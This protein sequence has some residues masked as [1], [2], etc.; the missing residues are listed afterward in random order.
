M[1]KF[2]VYVLDQP[3]GNNGPSGNSGRHEEWNLPWEKL[4]FDQRLTYKREGETE[5]GRFRVSPLSAPGNAQH[6]VEPVPDLPLGGDPKKD[7][8]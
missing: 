5:E 3:S 7:R 1:P 2:R 4:V 6:T 8:P